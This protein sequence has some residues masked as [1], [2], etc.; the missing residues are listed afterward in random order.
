M[1]SLGK[2]LKNLEDVKTKTLFG[3]SGVCL[4]DVYSQ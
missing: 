4:N 2:A 3:Q 1:W